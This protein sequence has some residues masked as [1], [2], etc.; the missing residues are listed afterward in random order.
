[1]NFRL[2]GSF[3]L[4]NK[5]ETNLFISGLIF[6]ANLHKWPRGGPGSRIGF[7]FRFSRLAIH[8]GSQWVAECGSAV[9]GGR[10]ALCGLR[11]FG[12]YFCGFHV[13][14]LHQTANY[15]VSIVPHTHGS[16]GI[17]CCIGGTFRNVAERIRR[18]IKWPQCED[19]ALHILGQE[20]Q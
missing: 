8:H 14:N 10:M 2:L 12:V 7:R 6:L 4:A 19:P 18:T 11:V 9:V 20:K 3:I 5:A 17:L 1:M 13:V 16:F 15:V